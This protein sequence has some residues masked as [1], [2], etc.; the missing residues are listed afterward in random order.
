MTETNRRIA[1]TPAQAV[2]FLKTLAGLVEKSPVAYSADAAADLAAHIRGMAEAVTTEAHVHPAELNTTRQ[3]AA[4][5][6]HN[7]AV[8]VLFAAE[9]R[10]TF[11]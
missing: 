4:L 3:Y 10:S 7:E 1:Q 6:W 8:A 2:V 11:H 5:D 9:H